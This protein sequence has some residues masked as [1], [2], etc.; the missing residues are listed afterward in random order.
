MNPADEKPTLGEALQA[1]FLAGEQVVAGRFSSR[2]GFTRQGVASALRTMEK[3]GLVHSEHIERGGSPIV[4]YSCINR[5]GMA[6]RKVVKPQFN[7][8]AQFARMAQDFSALLEV[9]GIRA[10]DIPLPATRH[11]IQDPEVSL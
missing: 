5:A 2:H 9:W 10:A 11:F 7:P 6:A 4:V 1:A 3:H 8:M